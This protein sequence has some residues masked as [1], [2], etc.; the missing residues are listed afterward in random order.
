M[1][2]CRVA[3]GTGP[4]DDS[5]TVP[6]TI[7]YEPDDAEAASSVAIEDVEQSRNLRDGDRLGSGYDALDTSTDALME[8]EEFA[9]EWGRPV[10]ADG[11][12]LTED[13]QLWLDESGSPVYAYD[14]PP[15]EGQATEARTQ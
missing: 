8:A 7:V 15:P 1:R 4:D 10:D 12:L 14:A 11:N 3:S 2:L 9:D 5:E 6:I 13:G